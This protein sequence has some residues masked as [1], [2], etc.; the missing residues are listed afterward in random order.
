MPRGLHFSKALFEGLIHGG[1]YFR[2]F[3]VSSCSVILSEL[4]LLKSIFFDKKWVPEK[5]R[6]TFSSSKYCRDR[7]CYSFKNCG[8]LLP[9]FRHF[10]GFVSSNVSNVRC[11]HGTESRRLGRVQRFKMAKID[12]FSPF[13]PTLWLEKE[14]LQWKNLQEVQK[15][16][17]L[18]CEYLLLC[19]SK[20][21]VFTKL[22]PAYDENS[23]TSMVSYGDYIQ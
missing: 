2:N 14:I 22:P 16:E 20:L 7:K 13:Y 17:P 12:P 15:N 6:L 8:S 9:W 3:T 23:W 19:V 10:N 18:G 1:A 4:P 21:E 5:A 11:S